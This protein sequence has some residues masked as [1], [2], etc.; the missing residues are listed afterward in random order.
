VR[1]RKKTIFRK[2]KYATS[3][4][5][6]ASYYP[7]LHVIGWREWISLPDIKIGFIK[8]KI[9]TGARTSALHAYDIEE[10][11]INR[12]HH[13]RFKVHPMQKN[14]ER[15]IKAEALLVEK[16][17]VRDSSGNESLRPVIMTDVVIGNLRWQI[18]LTL[19]NRDQMGFRML[20]GREAVRGHLLV[21]PARSFILGKTKK[22]KTKSKTKTKSK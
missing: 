22:V 20:L 7:Q 3:E 14:V 5:A 17:L 1:V 18:E 19:V 9:D 16:R 15:V 6:H 4:K 12:K 11:I 2:K 10:V 21:N 13:V 8:A